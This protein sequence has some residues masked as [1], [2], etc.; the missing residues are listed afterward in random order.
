MKAY[1]EQNWINAVIALILTILFENGFFEGQLLSHA[2]IEEIFRFFNPIY[3]SVVISVTELLIYLST[4][5]NS[6]ASILLY[7]IIPTTLH[8]FNGWLMYRY[9]RIWILIPTIAIHAIWN[10]SCM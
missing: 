2:A 7:R 8:L 5:N 9:P 4:D 1:I 10:Y 6:V 3:Y